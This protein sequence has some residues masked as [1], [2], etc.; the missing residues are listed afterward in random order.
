MIITK[1]SEKSEDD[2][3]YGVTSTLQDTPQ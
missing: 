2:V 3:S 1:N